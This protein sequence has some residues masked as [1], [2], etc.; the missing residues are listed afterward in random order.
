[1]NLGHTS[2]RVVLRQTSRAWVLREAA[3]RPACEA[4]SRG[5]R[6]ASRSPGPSLAS[7]RL[8]SE[9]PTRT[10]TR[11][12]PCRDMS[13]NAHVRKRDARVCTPSCTR[14]RGRADAALP[15]L[16]F[17]YLAANR[18][19]RFGK[20]QVPL[21]LCST[22]QPLPSAWS[23]GA[24]L[25]CLRVCTHVCGGGITPTQSVT[26]SLNICWSPGRWHWREGLPVCWGSGHTS[27]PPLP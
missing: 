27:A 18:W 9:F 26:G 2:D 19:I 21:T 12:T 14:V 3:S 17:R 13:Q 5:G 22:S 4:G 24:F 16:T 20:T 10:Q 8:L 7:W 15:L 1:M 25:V 6:G 11:A 23:C